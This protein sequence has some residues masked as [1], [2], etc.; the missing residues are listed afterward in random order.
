[1]LLKV[2]RGLSFVSG[3]LIR[4]FFERRKRHGKEDPNRIYERYGNASK[5]RP[6]GPLVWFHAASVGEINS[7]IS[8]INLLKQK[9]SGVVFLV[10]TWTVTSAALIAKR[11]PEGIIHQFVPIDRPTW[12]RRFLNYWQPDLA[13]WVESEIWP[14][15]IT[16]IHNRKIPIVLLNGRISFR[17]FQSWRHLPTTIQRILHCFTLC[18]AQSDLDAERLKA[19]GAGDIRVSG[20][21]KYAAD[22]LPADDKALTDLW[23]AIGK[24]PIWICVST[25]EGEEQ[26]VVD[27]HRVITKTHPELL[28]MII[29]RHPIRA[30]K[31]AKD[32]SKQ[33]F[34]IS[35]R[36]SKDKINNS[37][38]IYIADT[39]GEL[40]LFYRLAPIAFIGGTLIPHGGQNL[41][42]AAKLDCAIVHGPS[43]TNF[44][45]ITEEMTA[46]QGSI[47]IKSKTELPAAIISLLVDDSRRKNQIVA[48]RRVVDAKEKI[49]EAVAKEL[50][51]V[52][53][54]TV[55]SQRQQQSHARA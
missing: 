30:N 20:N 28:T 46:A 4:I 31:I 16:E 11:I 13:F 29:P 26:A 12:I 14:N 33:G 35:L 53:N 3:P 18:F 54:R 9:N 44:A 2:Y 52:L 23:T 41:L 48:A 43:M 55:L 8:L 40:G 34:I 17:S 51:P 1:M 32:L 50:D 37:T 21:L 15:L 5:C 36:S 25:H 19:L 49:L 24:R 45:S 47:T 7:V 27:A 38:E 39:V 6:K 10:T 22:P 42:E